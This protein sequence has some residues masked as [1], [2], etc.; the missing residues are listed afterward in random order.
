MQL[1]PISLLPEA[2]L[3]SSACLEEEWEGA[4]VAGT[5]CLE[6]CSEGVGS[7]RQ[8]ADG[9]IRLT[10][11]LERRGQDSNDKSPPA[12]QSE[13]LCCLNVPSVLVLPSP[14]LGAGCVWEKGAEGLLA[15]WQG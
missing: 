2:A 14:G 15:G 1:S 7:K 3:R 13:F 8:E 6:S 11:P 12:P 5:G 4:A 9:A 10:W